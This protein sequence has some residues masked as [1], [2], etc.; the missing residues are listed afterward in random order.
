LLP[1][2]N[3]WLELASTGH[4]FE[5]YCSKNNWI[6]PKISLI[7]LIVYLSTCTKP[8]KKLVMYMFAGIQKSTKNKQKI[9]FSILSHKYL[10]LL[11]KWN[12]NWRSQ[13]RDV[14]KYFRLYINNILRVWLNCN[15]QMYIVNSC[16]LNDSWELAFYPQVENICMTAH[17]K[18]YIFPFCHINI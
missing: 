6:C 14:L 16:N 1:S 10:D 5:L 13:E 12:W 11:I 2:Y 7:S 18:K 15:T 8:R 3:I 17:N 4:S 9:H